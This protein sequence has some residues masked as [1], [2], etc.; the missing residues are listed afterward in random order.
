M[1]DFKFDDDYK[2]D[3]LELISNEE[4]DV[5]RVNLELFYNST[6]RIREVYGYPMGDFVGTYHRMVDYKRFFDERNG[7]GF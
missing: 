2:R 6:V 5:L 1:I 3:C 7:E 4:V